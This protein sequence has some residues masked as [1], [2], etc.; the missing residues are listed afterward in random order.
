[1]I[2]LS[3]MTANRERKGGGEARRE[4]GRERK[5]FLQSDLKIS[6]VS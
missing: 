5:R 6:L 4:K 1:M 3:S 2:R